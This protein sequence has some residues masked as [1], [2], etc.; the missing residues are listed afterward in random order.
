VH[1]DAD[2]PQ[3]H[4]SFTAFKAFQW[5]QVLSSIEQEKGWSL[6]PP[7]IFRYAES[8][9]KLN[10]EREGIE[11]WFRLFIR[12]SDDAERFIQQSCHRLMSTDWHSFAEL[13]PELDSALFPAWVLIKKPALAKNL[14]KA[15]LMK[16]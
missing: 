9:F 4:L 16:P 3:N 2:K 7:L 8:C 12:F 5:Q 10:R 11:Y 13:D 14:R 6:Q 15:L 1:Y